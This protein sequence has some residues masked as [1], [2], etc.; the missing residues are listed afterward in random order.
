MQN[1]D[2]KQDINNRLFKHSVK[3][4]ILTIFLIPLFH[5]V[6]LAQCADILDTAMLRPGRFDR[7][8]QIRVGRCSGQE[9]LTI[10]DALQDLQNTKRMKW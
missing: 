8:I 7:K 6:S 3:K 2:I 1:N 9:I 10:N 5:N 4:W